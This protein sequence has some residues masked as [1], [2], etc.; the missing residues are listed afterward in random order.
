[1][2][3]AILALV[4]AGLGRDALKV[5]A[6]IG[7]AVFLALAFTVSSL[8]TLVGVGA[9]GQPAASAAASEIPPD[10]LVE[11]QQVAAA[12]CGLPWTVLA[13]I[14]KVESDFGRNMTTSSAGAIGYG[15]FLPST[16]VAY[17]QGNPYDYHDALPAMARYLC[18]NGAPGD[19]HAAIWA[20]NH[21][22]WYVAEVLTLAARYG[23]ALPAAPTSRVVA[24]AQAEL[25]MPYVWGGASPAT[26]FDCSGLVQW[27][28][29]Q[30]DVTL[31][32]TAQEQFDA[33]VRLRPDQLQ[34]GDLV[35]FAHT[36]PSADPITHVGI[37]VGNGTMINAP[38]EGEVVQEMPVFTGYWGAHYAGAGRVQ[39]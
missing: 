8:A 4:L 37:Y 31:P 28:Y 12:S 7:L 9:P 27:V 22:D 1:M 2:A 10:Q 3:Q 30:V 26:S 39:S 29:G 11:M 35:F 25:G 23:S 16:W 33:T 6:G 36:Y 38:E 15:Q 5:A 34:P 19:L 32:R 20:Y 24:L 14:A 13:G 17:G 18:A 21:A